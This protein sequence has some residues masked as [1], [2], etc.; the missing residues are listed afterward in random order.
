LSAKLI[1][2][3]HHFMAWN[4]RINCVWKFAIDDMEIGAAHTAC[5]HADAH[6]VWR[7]RTFC[8]RYNR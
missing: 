7:E 1:N 3:A 2:P 4:D 6:L 8:E 5:M